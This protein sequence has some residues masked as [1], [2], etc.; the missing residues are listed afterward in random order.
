MMKTFIEQFVAV[1]KA[2]PASRKVSMALVLALVLG[3][4]AAMFFWANK[5][6]YQV[7]YTNLSP[8][9]AGSIVSQLR[10]QRVP[11]ELSGG[12]STVLVPS[13]NV[14]E[15]RLALANE[16]LPVGGHVGFEIFDQANF[17]TTQFVQ[18]LN[19]QRALQGELVRTISDF[20]EVEH[21]RVL[22]AMPEESVFVEDSRPPSASVFLKLRSSLSS[23]KV[24]GIVHLVASA[25]DGL[26]PELVTVVDSSGR[27]LH[28]GHSEGGQTALLAS[29]KLEYQHQV[30][31]QLAGRVQSMLEGIIG[32]NK[33]IV[34]ASADIDFEQIDLSEETFDPDSSVVR[35]K[36]RRSES[37]DKGNP[38]SND[39]KGKASARKEDEVVN[40]EISRITRHV[41]KPSG[42]I[43]RISVSAVVDGTYEVVTSGDGSETK[44]YLPRS[45]EDL[46]QF[47]NVV[48]NAIGFDGER[49]DQVYVSSFPLSVSVEP[50]FEEIQGID[51][52]A[53]VRQYSKT[54]INL[55]LVFLVFMFVVRPLLKS[56]KT[57]GPLVQPRKR[58]PVGEGPSDEP[59]KLAEG[60]EVGMREKTMRL[61]RDNS[62]RT[63]Q[64]IRGWLSEDH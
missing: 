19:Y 25:V 21:A 23:A 59:A 10:E 2:M 22:L 18:R 20:G 3:G 26:T 17:S 4:F 47:E 24:A 28:K 40:Y 41:I 16:G 54:F 11:Y 30:E 60:A 5:I 48:K 49:G 55:A 42:A 8:E 44:K 1:F 35:S 36:Q 56:V 52:L 46:R 45:E 53:L 39:A 50:S 7:L 13:E 51:W 38:L 27:V 29:N 61:A 43:K 37:S 58:L 15:L 34:R 63:E 6:D 33:A 57:M 32:K 9:D 31:S 12:G 64:L 14:Y 62:E